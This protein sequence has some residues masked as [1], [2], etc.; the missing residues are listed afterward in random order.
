MLAAAGVAL[1]AGMPLGPAH[2]EVG[3]PQLA[4]L[5]GV[6]RLGIVGRPGK[7]E[8]GPLRA[9]R[10]ALGV[11]EVGGEIPPFD[12]ELGVAAVVFG[13][14]EGVAGLWDGEAFGG[15]GGVAPLFG[16]EGRSEQ[17]LRRK[18]VVPEFRWQGGVSPDPRSR[19]E[20]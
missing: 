7:A 4:V 1:E 12:F 3:H 16:G 17:F 20:H 19:L 10:T 18:F 2:G 11:P 15:V 6:G 14:G 13:E 9:V 5:P 8:Q